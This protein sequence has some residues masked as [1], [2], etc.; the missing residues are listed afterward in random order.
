M[1]KITYNE[2]LDRVYGCWLGKCVSGT[3]GAPYEGAK[4]LFEFNYDP[5][6]IASML[7][8][9]DLD[10]QILWLHVLEQKGVAFTTMDLAKAFAELCPY[11]PGEYATFRRNYRLGI[12][13]PVSGWFNN[14]YYLEGNGCPIRSEIWACIAPGNPQLAADISTKDGIMDHC[15]TSVDEERFLAAI[16]AAAFFEQDLDRLFEI[17]LSVIPEDGKVYKMV[18]DTLKWCAEASTW[19]QVRGHIIR[20]YGHPDCTNSVQN[21]AFAIMS[22]KFGSLDMIETTMIALNAGYDTD[23]TCA[24]A[25]SIIGIIRGAKYLQKTHGFED[26]GYVLGVNITRKNDRLYDLSVDTC[27]MGLHFAQHLNTDLEL[28]D[29]PAAPDIKLPEPS[30]LEFR[31]EYLPYTARYGNELRMEAM[32][33]IGLGD[34]RK[35]KITIANRLGAPS[36]SRMTLSIPAGWNS[37]WS[38]KDVILQPAEAMSVEVTLSVPAD[39]PKLNQTNIIKLDVATADGLVYSHNFGL[40]GAAVW[41]A[42]GPFWK[43]RADMSALQPGQSYYSQIHC[44]GTEQDGVD[45]VRFYHLNAMA[46]LDAMELDP[47]VIAESASFDA[48]DA[49]KQAMVVC[50]H[51]DL[52]SMNDL[53]GYQGPCAMILTQQFECPEEREVGITLGHTD[54]YRLWLNGV[55]VSRRDQVD[56]WTCEN[57][58]IIKQKLKKGLNTLVWRI[59]RRSQNAQ[60]SIQFQQGNSCSDIYNDFTY[61]NPVV[62]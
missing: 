55:E 53:M 10:L 42:Y 16:E 12:M 20:H 57:S 11:A 3:I 56:W 18:T 48:C 39:L 1:M 62:K 7:P 46:E 61:I 44:D 28:V 8:N 49:A 59:V 14:H 43:N 19:Q 60:F 4:E 22:L 17:G 25:G 38:E 32:P 6:M 40:S 33:S 31:T 41:A 58:H 34:S 45:Q 51:E 21:T 54:A 47:E 52:F 37:D 50:T 36:A 23:C 29:A 24:T 15:G 2:Y 27:M 30:V 9:D 5:A 26:P 13:P 35:V